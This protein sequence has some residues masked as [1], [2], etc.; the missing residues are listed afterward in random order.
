MRRWIGGDRQGIAILLQFLLAGTISIA[1]VQAAAEKT[2]F[3]AS[4][5]AKEALRGRIAVLLDIRPQMF[6]LCSQGKEGRRR[7]DRGISI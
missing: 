2:K 1:D 4:N 7:G 6:I 3:R 5:F